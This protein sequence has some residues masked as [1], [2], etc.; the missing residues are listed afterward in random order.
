MSKLQNLTIHALSIYKNHTNQLYK[1]PAFHS[2]QFQSIFQI[3]N[4]SRPFRVSW[5][6]NAGSTE[7]YVT[8]PYY[9]LSSM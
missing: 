7:R 5:T 9:S 1:S 4:A 3:I 6:G 8:V 2:W